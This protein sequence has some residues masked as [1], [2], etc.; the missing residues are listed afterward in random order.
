MAVVTVGFDGVKADGM[1]AATNVTNIGGGAGAAVEPDI[2]YENT[3]S[4]SRKVGT[5]QRGFYTTTGATR[6]MTAARRNTVIMK[7]A[8][9][10]WSALDPQSTPGLQLSVGS[11]ASAY[12]S[13]TTS[14]FDIYQAIGG[15]T[16]YA[17]DPNEVEFRNSTTGSPT[18]SSAN[19]FAIEADFSATSKSENVVMDSVDYG[20]GLNLTG[21]DG[22]SDD[23]IF[24]DF[25][26]ADEG[27]VAN[28]WGFVTS[29]SGIMFAFGKLWIGQNTSQ[30]SVAT[31][32]TDSNVTVVFP[33][34]QFAT[35]FSGL[36]LDL[37]GTGTTISVDSC[38]FVGRGQGGK[39]LFPVGEV[40][41]TNDDLDNSFEPPNFHTDNTQVK[42]V[43]YSN[44][45][46]A[47]SIGLTSGNSYFYVNDAFYSTRAN[48]DADT[49]RIALTASTAGEE[50]SLEVVSNTKPILEVTGTTGTATFTNCSFINFRDITINSAVTMSGCNFIA[51]ESLDPST[52][53]FDGCSVIGGAGSADILWNVATNPN[54]IIDNM[55]FIDTPWSSTGNT[56]IV[57]HAIELGTTVSTAIT[58]TGHTY[59]DFGFAPLSFDTETDVTGGATDSITITGHGLGAFDDSNS[60]VPV[61][62]LDDGGTETIGLTDGAIYYAR[63]ADANTIY[64]YNNYTNA[65]VGTTTGRIDLTP[66]GG[67]SGETHLLASTRATIFNNSGKTVTVT[68]S[69]GDTPTIRNAP[70]SATTVVNSVNVTISGLR[71]NTEVRIYEENTTT[72]I[73][74]IENATAGSPDARTFTF[75]DTAGNIVDIRIFNKEYEPIVLESFTI[76]NDPVTLPQQQR[77]DRNYSNP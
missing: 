60:V 21:G 7:V 73:D 33:N 63:I 49:S 51:C 56:Q 14:L 69:G 71:D 47:A 20:A 12:Y 9:G 35:D 74:G 10:N 34:G 39:S 22:A 62:Y 59:T 77:F 50:H 4:V 8:I 28:R 75:S 17:I 11:G 43:T 65:L 61:V 27:T 6:D 30:A 38:S 29:K 44:E 55:T 2:F 15:F 1:D 67:G 37:G 48:A 13:Y 24:Q 72:E 16:F 23:G 26:D 53:D 19:Y 5:A 68:V 52:G 40:N 25:I 70:G 32:F 41:A 3:G 31:G 45:G 54:G 18:L 46:G 66:S 42:Y 64:L 58:L 36:G 57:H 76:P